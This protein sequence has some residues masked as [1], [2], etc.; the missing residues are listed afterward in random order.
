MLLSVQKLIA[1]L[2]LGGGSEEDPLGRPQLSLCGDR[3]AL[4]ARLWHAG[5]ARL[6]VASGCTLDGVN[7]LQDGGAE[8]RVL[9]LELGVPDSAILVVPERCW[10][11][12]DEIA[13]HRRLQERFG[14]RRIGLLGS[15]GHLPRTLALAA[16]AG[17][18]VTPVGADWRGR[19]H[20]FQVRFLVPQGDGF[21]DVQRACWEY[22][23][24]WIGR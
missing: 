3:V 4:A 12:R 23:G 9:W 22:L 11:T 8:T 15:A 10:V 2:V 19:R 18:Q 6:L 24:R 20:V 7:G 5:K 1:L 21:M 16:R 14:W 13:A 17:L